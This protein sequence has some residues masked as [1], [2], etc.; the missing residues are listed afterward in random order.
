MDTNKLLSEG[1]AASVLERVES[2]IKCLHTGREL[3]FEL[4]FIPAD[5]MFICELCISVAH[6]R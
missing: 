5:E 4:I 6:R 3:H 1:I 2:R